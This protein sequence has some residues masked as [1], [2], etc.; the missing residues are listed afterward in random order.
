MTLVH[1]A[2]LIAT[3]GMLNYVVFVVSGLAR[4]IATI[5]ILWTYKE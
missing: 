2:D 5:A 3:A 4:M 1:L